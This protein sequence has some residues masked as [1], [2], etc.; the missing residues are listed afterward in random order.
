MKKRILLLPRWY[1]NKT[2]IQ[3][4]T[5][6]RQQALLMKDDFE[7]RVIYVQADP[8]TTEKYTIIENTAEGIHELIVY[9][10]Q[11]KGPLRKII[12]ARRYER[13]QKRAFK[14]LNEKPDLCH[15]HVPYRSAF[16][17][18]ALLRKYQIPFV[19][20]EHWSGHLTGA[21]LQKRQFDKLLYA[22]VLEKAKA[23]SCVSELLRARFKS[24]TGYDAAVIPNYIETAA[25]RAAVQSSTEIHILSV[26][27]MADEIK[28]ISGLVR[29]FEQALKQNSNLR[30]TLIGGGPDEEK[31]KNLVQ[32]LKLSDRIT[33]KGRL[34]HSEVLAAMQKCHFYVCNSNFETFGMTVAEALRSGKPVVSTRC[35]GPEEFL[36]DQN[37]LVVSP[38]RP[39]EL[40]SAMLQMAST[41]HRYNTESI[42][43]EIENRFG[44]DA[45]RKKWLSFYAMH[46]PK[47]M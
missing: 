35:G 7:I 47:E 34:R 16:L 42:A 24:N 37:S 26:S 25:K 19:I 38:G 10:K 20:T 27:D 21:Y 11:N 14:Q 15:V 5:F 4:G 46:L 2:D 31:I 32:S 9:F 28:N 33:L 30:L 39:V 44:K 17:A 6:I 41:Y 3:L 18:L 40:K 13:A 12:N 1:P 23:I 8:D 45:V 22:K 36:H 29:A 43:T